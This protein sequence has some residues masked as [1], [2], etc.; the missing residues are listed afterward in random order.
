MILV[1]LL[2]IAA[3]VYAAMETGLINRPGQARTP[4]AANQAAEDGVPNAVAELATNRA[5]DGSVVADARVVPVQA[6][7]LTLTAGGIVAEVLVAEGEQ[8]DAGQ[9]LLRLVDAQARVGVAQAQAGLQRAQA[10]LAQLTAGARPEAVA[11]AQ[12]ALDAAISR[13][14]RLAAASLPGSIADAEARLAEAQADLAQVLEG[15]SDQRMIR[16]RAEVA[17]AEADLRQAQSAYNQVRWRADIGALPEA[18]ELQKATIDFEA[19]QAELADLEAGATQAEIASASAQVRRARAQLET[20][21]AS[22]PSDLGEAE[23]NVRASQ[24]QLDQL[25]A[26][27]R[28]EEVAAAEAE[29]AAATATLQQALVTLADTEL[30]APFR[31]TVA[32]LLVTIGEHA[33]P[34]SPVL[35]LA[36]LTTWQIET[37]DLTELDIVGIDEATP[38][39]LTFDAIADLEMNGRVQYIRP[40][41]QDNRGDIVYTVVIAPAQQDARLRWNMTAVV[42][43]GTQ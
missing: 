38:V 14:E 32:E 26:G 30:R 22:Q 31:G 5:L 13:Y 40:L 18:A 43:L 11:A 15:P 6:A 39:T 9:L 25:L 20:V 10:Q 34:S 23:A 17:A 1:L 29:V 3:G 27:S 36:D 19:A 35:R 8:V 7:A 16:A 37:E 24:A 2:L 12:A 21:Q 41:G 4:T 33:A 42:T 28:A